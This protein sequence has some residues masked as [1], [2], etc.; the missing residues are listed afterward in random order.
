M[1][2][3]G[4]VLCQPAGA[5]WVVVLEGF[6]ESETADRGVRPGPDAVVDGHA[7]SEVSGRRSALPERLRQASEEVLARA[8][9]EGTATTIRAA[10]GRRRQQQA[11]TVRGDLTVLQSHRH[12]S[13]LPDRAEPPGPQRHPARDVAQGEELRARMGEVALQR[14]DH[15]H[16]GT[17]QRDPRS[18]LE[19]LEAVRQELGRVAPQDAEVDVERVVHADH[20]DV[21]DLV[22]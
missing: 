7:T 14:E 20:G 11:V 16:E 21:P 22:G 18:I 1:K 19:N 9:G 13:D 5:P 6:S 2:L 12:E 4:G 15:G 17:Y 10:P 3:L 8:G